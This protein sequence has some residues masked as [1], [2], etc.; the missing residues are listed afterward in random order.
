MRNSVRLPRTLLGLLGTVLVVLLLSALPEVIQ[1]SDGALQLRPSA[2]WHI[3]VDYLQGLWDGSSLDYNRGTFGQSGDFLPTALRAVRTSLPYAG[4]ALALALGVA[5]GLGLVL[6]GTRREHLQ[7]VI[8]GV[9]AL[10]DFILVLV[11]QMGAVAVYQA[12]GWRIARVATI[13]SDQRALLLPLIVLSVIPTAFLLKGTTTAVRHTLA[14]EFI[15]TARAQGLSRGQVLRRHVLPHALLH[16]EAVSSRLAALLVGNLVI[17]EYL[18]N[19]PGLGRLA[20][21]YLFW[22]GYQPNVAVNTMLLLMLLFCLLWL[23]TYLVVSVLRLV[24]TGRWR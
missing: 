21:T 8:S 13:S 15:R 2:F 24:A 22:R 7:D 16:V 14:R 17:V 5:V 9:G 18:F 10:P 23:G 19:I 12:T 11:L 3:P 4:L 20:F 1:L 6:G